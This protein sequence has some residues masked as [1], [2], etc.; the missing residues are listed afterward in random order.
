VLVLL[1]PLM[2]DWRRSG[3]DWVQTG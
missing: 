3:G 2:S 1:V